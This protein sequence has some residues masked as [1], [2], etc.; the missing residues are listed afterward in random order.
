MIF[1]KS[2]KGIQDNKS[3]NPIINKNLQGIIK[4]IEEFSDEQ[5]EIVEK[6]KTE[7][8]IFTGERTLE[9]CLQALN[10]SM[11]LA[12]T[13][14]KLLQAHKE[15]G[16]LLE[17]ELKKLIDKKKEEIYVRYN[18]SIINNNLTRLNKNY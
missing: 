13:R 8:E 4:T 7:M 3:E 11:Q 2:K 12:N 9:S 10:L 17:N 6:F 15:Y 16:N 14:E 18:I 1:F 5:R